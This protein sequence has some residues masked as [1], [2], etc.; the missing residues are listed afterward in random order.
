M[1]AYQSNFGGFISASA[2]RRASF[3][4]E[5]WFVYVDESISA[6]YY[7]VASALGYPQDG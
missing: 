1:V 5:R 3:A 6:V 7:G 2:L 4:A